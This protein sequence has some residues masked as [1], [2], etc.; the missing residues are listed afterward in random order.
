M[1][2]KGES[3]TTNSPGYALFKELVDLG[4]NVTVYD[5]VVQNNYM[6][7]DVNFL[8]KFDL[9]NLKDKFDLIVVNIKMDHQEQFTLGCFEKM[10]GRVHIC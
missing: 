8:S 7:R 6:K 3:L 9:E 1:V 4:K 2:K 10:G 5:R